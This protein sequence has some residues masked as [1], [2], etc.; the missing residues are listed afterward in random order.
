MCIPEL[1]WPWGFIRASHVALVV[2]KLPV[3]AGDTRDASL[4]PR[5][6]R[7]P[8]E[9]NGNPLQY[10]CLENLMDRGAWQATVHRVAKSQTQLTRLS[11]HMLGIHWDQTCMWREGGVGG[12]GCLNP[13]AALPR[14]G[15]G[16]WPLWGWAEKW[17]GCGVLCSAT[18][19][20]G[21]SWTPYNL[22]L[23]LFCT[24]WRGI[25]DS[26]CHGAWRGRHRRAGPHWRKW[27]R[28]ELTLPEER[29]APNLSFRGRFLEWKKVHAGS[30]AAL[31]NIGGFD[32]HR[33]S[34][35]FKIN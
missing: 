32:K 27:G 34:L 28:P 4:I 6:G 29:A 9:G 24:L 31:Q 22:W 2:K 7:S 33:F 25:R 16:A 13:P 3:N 23:L 5:L 15:R 10:S 26:A 12:A 30:Q 18:V 17:L 19:A 11:T 14:T 20:S 8:R 21:R 35:F 1:S